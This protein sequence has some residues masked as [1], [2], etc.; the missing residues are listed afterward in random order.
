MAILLRRVS[1]IIYPLSRRHAPQGHSH[2]CAAV[3]SSDN[4]VFLKTGF[5]FPTYYHMMNLCTGSSFNDY[6]R[7]K[8]TNGSALWL[9]IIALKARCCLYYW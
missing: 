3:G 1:L 8:Y 4:I 2:V 7:A 5:S 6:S 9:L